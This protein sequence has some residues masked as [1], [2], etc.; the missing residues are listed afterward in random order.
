MQKHYF[1]LKDGSYFLQFTKEEIYKQI[2]NSKPETFLPFLEMMDYPYIEYEWQR[3]LKHFPDRQILGR[4]LALMRLKGFRGFTYADSDWL[5][6][7]R[8]K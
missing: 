8:R 1:V 6:E 3:M 7:V 4:Y 5:N 2:D